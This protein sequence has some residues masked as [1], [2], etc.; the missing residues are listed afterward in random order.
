MKKSEDAFNK[1]IFKK[2]F[3]R[4]HNSVVYV[5]TGSRCSQILAEIK[6]TSEATGLK[7]TSWE[8]G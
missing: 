4:E 8:A 6:E 3:E 5:L 1:C 7:Q 2:R